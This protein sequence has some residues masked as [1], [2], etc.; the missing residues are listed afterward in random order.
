M[1]AWGDV[2]VGLLACGAGVLAGGIAV[3]DSLLGLLACGAEV[4]GGLHRPLRRGPG[5]PAGLRPSSTMRHRFDGR[6]RS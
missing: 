1:R 6:T 2:V 5:L 4:L 3:G